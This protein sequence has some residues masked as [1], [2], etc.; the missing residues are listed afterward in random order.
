MTF[1]RYVW[2]RPGQFAVTDWEFA[3]T[4]LSAALAADSMVEEDAPSLDDV[5]GATW[6]PVLDFPDMVAL[7]C[8][9]AGMTRPGW[10][11][12]DPEDAGAPGHPYIGMH[13]RGLRWTADVLWWVRTRIPASCLEP[14]ARRAELVFDGV[15]H[16]AWVWVD[17]VSAGA[18]RGMFGG[19]ILDVSEWLSGGT[20]DHE[21]ILALRPVGAGRGKEIGW[22]TKGR[23]VK[24]ETFCRWI[25]NPDLMTCG[26]WQPVRLVQ[27][28]D[29]RLDRPRVTTRLSDDGSA[30]VAVEV[31]VLRADISPDLHWVQR[32]G[33]V[34]ATW[35]PRF[36]PA[37]ATGS[38]VERDVTVTCTDPAGKQV[39]VATKTV[40][41]TPGRVWARVELTVLDPQLW[42][43]NEMAPT[44]NGPALHTIG[45][46]LTDTVRS[47]TDESAAL[48]TATDHL[49]V[50]TGL[51]E[52]AWE[53]AAGPRLADHWADWQARVNGRVVTGPLRG[54]NWMPQ[55]LLRQDRTRL[56]HFLT[57]M[58]DA[59]VQLVRVWGGGLVETEDFYDI[60]DELGLLVWQDFPI[61]TLYDC[62]AM[63]LDVWEQ[64]VTWSA[65]RLRNRASLAVWCGGNEF[66]PYAPENAAVVGILERTLL[67]LD[68]T[69]PFVRACSDPG[70][71][72]PYLECDSTWYLPL[73]R[74]A[75]AVSE[76]GGHTLPTVAS[77]A[78]ILPS[79]EIER[80]LSSL[81]S[82]G[83]EG[84]SATHP[85]LQHHWAEFQPDRIPRMIQRTRPHDDLS[86]P[87]T[88][89]SRGVDAIQLGAAELYQSV[90]SDFSLGDTAARL[91]MPWVYNRAWPSVGMQVVDHSGRPTLGWFAIRRASGPAAIVLRP[92]AEAVAPG[93]LL[94]LKV[95]LTLPAVTWA[96]SENG[97]GAG[98]TVEVRVYDQSLQELAVQRLDL[99]PGPAG[100]Q[101]ITV[102]PRARGTGE[103]R[104]MIVLAADIADLAVQHVRVIRVS[105]SL[106]DP[107]V[108]DAYRSAPQQSAHF[109]PGSLRE[110]VE[111]APAVVRWSVAKGEDEADLGYSFVLTCT[112]DSDAPAAVVQVES[113]DPLWMVLPEDSG[114][115]IPPH[116]VRRLRVRVRPTAEVSS[117]VTEYPAIGSDPREAIAVR[118]WN[119]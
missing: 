83:Q 115:W 43:P 3:G 104:A 82:T 99:L 4:P 22:G 68:G 56:R 85:V 117:I 73:Y 45:I 72:H 44:G 55:D 70:D 32:H 30:H 25:N 61:N 94:R 114:F 29:H 87:S 58:R 28:G 17:G 47:G 91:L 31:E 48:P 90:L 109:M 46:D 2:P 98:R 81:V 49:D 15:D 26:I 36:L 1:P 37:D 53:R 24:P 105:A 77:L 113:S 84:F 103:V 107:V 119:V 92:A 67:D 18:H 64:Q 40:D 38:P 65:E 96:T 66:D 11:G 52:I 101:G 100:L 51:R 21:I 106:S 97:L 12:P 16:D 19:P 41:V 27:T 39:A 118:G 10:L 20:G 33:G 74:E 6:R 75:P 110:A 79:G 50:R 13:S 89:F 42:W 60:C 7:E 63:P 71:V 5:R 88:T 34:P 54:M 23:L 76:W 14:W 80:P 86:A 8:A 78:E 95:G 112:N 116:A 69:R 57:L 9:L 62:S 111:T 59:G 35:D 102:D 93:E 108:R